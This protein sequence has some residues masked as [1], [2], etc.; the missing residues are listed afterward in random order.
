MFINDFNALTGIKRISR[1][2]IARR[3]GETPANL[4]QKVNRDYLA[5]STMKDIC[6]VMGIK[7]SVTYTDAETGEVVLKSDL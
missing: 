3:L 6:E 7:V 2:E 4:G 5:D 1:A